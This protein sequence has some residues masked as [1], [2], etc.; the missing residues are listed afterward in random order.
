MQESIEKEVPDGSSL[1]NECPQPVSEKPSS[2]EN[3]VANVD[4]TDI[5]IQNLESQPVI[6][7][8]SK[9]EKLMSNGTWKRSRENEGAALDN[10][11]S[12]PVI[13][14][15]DDEVQELDS[16]SASHPPCKEQDSPLHVKKE[17]NIIDVDVLPSPS[18]KDISRKFCC[19]ACSN[20][21][22]TSEVHRHPLLDVIICGNCKFLVVEK[23]RLE[24]KALCISD[25]LTTNK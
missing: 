5:F 9:N 4:N 20:A 6:S 10:K 15:S 19:T 1:S 13:I 7:N 12:R 18:P 22:K 3:S 23:M 14:D 8:G 11:R 21:L 24:V 25:L 17:V 16:K 2:S